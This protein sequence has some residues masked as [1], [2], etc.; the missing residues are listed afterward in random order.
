MT[1]LIQPAY[2]PVLDFDTD[3]LTTGSVVL[4]DS[5]LGGKSWKLTS[6]NNVAAT[7]QRNATYPDLANCVLGFRIKTDSVAAD[8]AGAVIYVSF[9]TTGYSKYAYTT[10]PPRASS[11]TD[12]GVWFAWTKH[13]A[14]F[15]FEGGAVAADF[16][17]VKSIR[18]TIT[19]AL[20][21]TVNFSLD[22]VWAVPA[23]RQGI[24]TWTFDDSLSSQYA[25]AAPEL[26]S[27]GA[28]GT[29]F[30]IGGNIGSAGS[31][32]AGQVA[33]LVARG[34]DI[35]SHG[36]A[37]A[38]F[39]TLTDEQLT[40]DLEA[41]KAAITSAG[42]NSPKHVAAPY[43]GLNASQLFTVL[44]QH[45]TAR[46]IK[47]DVNSMPLIT[48]WVNSP[49]VTAATTQAAISALVDRAVAEGGWLVLCAHEIV[50]SGATGAQ[51]N[52]AIL[53]DTV[54]YALANGARVM[55]YSEAARTMSV[56]PLAKRSL[57]TVLT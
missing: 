51:T 52:K 28:T 34:H 7:G 9:D 4:D 32:T 47:S 42:A 39:T 21:K 11:F 15:T 24:V 16:A 18:L 53:S 40:A 29:F 27:V 13:V 33:D 55:N 35:Q 10:L 12:T 3:T 1:R 50:A 26:E 56:S 45:T 46:S 17:N 19:S 38:N 49:V 23:T 5:M 8:Y 25:L 31:F 57:V 48:P 14:G 20:G 54:T 37:H 22:D 44:Q 43:G 36:Y 41:A 30:T 6:V 2:R